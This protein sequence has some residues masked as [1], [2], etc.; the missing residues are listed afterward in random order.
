M[1]MGFTVYVE[2]T[3]YAIGRSAL[4]ADLVWTVI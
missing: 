4:K 2:S 3:E 1:L